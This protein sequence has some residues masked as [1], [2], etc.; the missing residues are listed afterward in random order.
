MSSQDRIAEAEQ[1]EVARLRAEVHA[2]YSQ[3]NYA[4]G[5]AAKNLRG[6]KGARRWAQ[7]MFLAGI[8]MSA[9][10]GVVAAQRDAARRDL[11]SVTAIADDLVRIGHAQV[12]VSKECI[13]ELQSFQ[14]WN[15]AEN[16][17]GGAL[18]RAYAEKNWRLRGV[19]VLVFT[20]PVRP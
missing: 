18:H 16:D 10:G 7:F 13:D 1:T 11:A 2:A 5:E 6:W 4:Q 14:P 20:R 12:A 19:E 3:R 9:A 15:P 8:A 17:F